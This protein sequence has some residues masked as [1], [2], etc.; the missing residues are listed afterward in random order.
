VHPRVSCRGLAEKAEK[1]GGTAVEEN[2]I[3]RWAV[4]ARGRV[5]KI[6]DRK[7]LEWGLSWV[8]TGLDGRPWAS[9]RPVVIAETDVLLL[10]QASATQKM[11]A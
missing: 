9:R 5:G 4:C 7:V 3:G 11:P 2:L 6:E 1:K 8:G 10:E